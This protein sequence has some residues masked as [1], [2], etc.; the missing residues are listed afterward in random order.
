MIRPS[1]DVTTLTGVNL[2]GKTV[3]DL[4]EDI[5]I[6]DAG[7]ISGTSKY[8][9][10]YTGFSGDV[11]EQSGNYLALHAASAVPGA[12]ITAEVIGGSGRVVTLDSDGILIARLTENATGVKFT[13][14]L[15]GSAYTTESLTLTFSEDFVKAEP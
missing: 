14:S 1:A 13:A 3:D 9:T 10:D 12:V 2:L 5:A 4:Q 11:S 15:P 6:S 8:V 7:V